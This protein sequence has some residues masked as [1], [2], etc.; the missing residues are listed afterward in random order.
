VLSMAGSF[1]SI[2]IMA[3]IA[4]LAAEAYGIVSDKVLNREKFD[5]DLKIKELEEQIATLK[6]KV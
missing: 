4:K 3:E 5:K 1:N 6:K 2:K